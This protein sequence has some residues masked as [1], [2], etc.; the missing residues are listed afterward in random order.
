MVGTRA[1]AAKTCGE[2][3]LNMP[4]IRS[5]DPGFRRLWHQGHARRKE[6]GEKEGGMRIMELVIYQI[7][8]TR[9]TTKM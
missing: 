8:Q 3:D 2:V 6:E 1:L 5:S 4:Y 7:S 9:L